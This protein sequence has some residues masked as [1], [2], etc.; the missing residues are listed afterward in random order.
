[1]LI[2]KLLIGLFTHIEKVKIPA[3]SLVFNFGIQHTPKQSIMKIQHNL[4]ALNHT[5]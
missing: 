3:E 4:K 5:F 2:S 1:M